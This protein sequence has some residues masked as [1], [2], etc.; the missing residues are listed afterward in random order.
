MI[1]IDTNVLL[2]LLV[3]DLDTQV[4]AAERF[5]ATHCSSEEPGYV[6]RVVIIEIVWALKGFYGY[7]R[8]QIAVAIRALLNVSEFEVESADEIHAALS[9][10]ETSAPGF[11]DC[12]L[13]RTNA[14]TGCNHTVTFDRRAAKLKGFKLLSGA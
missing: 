7:D 11:V 1:G 6:S 13:A 12:L 10:Y 8:T 4:R 5:I 9:D 3:R 14:A 2:R